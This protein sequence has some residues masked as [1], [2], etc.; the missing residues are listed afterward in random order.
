MKCQN[1][2][3]DF[4]SP[5]CP[6]C[7]QKQTAPGFSLT[8]VF[9]EFLSGL[10]NAEAPIVR[11]F[12]HMIQSPGKMVGD[13]ISGKRKAYM[14]PIKFFLFGVAFYFFVRWILDWDP[15][16]SA[17]GS[18]AP[19]TP[20]MRVNLWMS[21]NVNLL[22]PLWIIIMAVFDKLLFFRSPF[23]FIERLV[24]KFF[25]V[26]EYIIAATILIPLTKILPIFHLINFVI[27]FGFI[28]Y[29]IVSFHG[30]ASLLGILKAVFIALVTF[31]IYV[32]ICSILVAWSMGIPISDLMLRPQ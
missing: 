4:S 10:Y 21:A 16:V 32:S 31:P 17:V 3:S 24:H 12:V 22:L 14:S 1:C 29:S 2:D 25:T 20:A 7:G 8:E 28:S 27:I 13:Y 26:G 30:K 5:F 19:E 15:V 6:E 18:D 11:T 23:T 9:T